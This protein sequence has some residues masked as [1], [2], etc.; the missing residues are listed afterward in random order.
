MEN[1]GTGVN[2]I[3]S[4]FRLLF[5]WRQLFCWKLRPARPNASSPLYSRKHKTFQGRCK[6]N[7]SLWKWL[8]CCF[9]LAPGSFS[10]LEQ[11]G[12]EGHRIFRL[13]PCRLGSCEEL[14]GFCEPFEHRCP[15]LRLFKLEFHQRLMSLGQLPLQSLLQRHSL[16]QEE[17]QLQP[18]AF[19]GTSYWLGI[20]GCFPADCSTSSR[21]PCAT[22]VSV[23]LEEEQ[24]RLHDGCQSWRRRSPTRRGRRVRPTKQLRWLGVLGTSYKILRLPLHRNCGWREQATGR[25]DQILLRALLWGRGGWLSPHHFLHRQYV[26]G[27]VLPRACIFD[28]ATVASAGRSDLPLPPQLFNRV[29][30]TASLAV[31]SASGGVPSPFGGPFSP[32]FLLPLCTKSSPL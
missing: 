10:S 29:F 32:L 30:A 6:W 14:S 27:L 24:L 11:L 5:D 25:G 18:L 17:H 16:L 23:E 2:L 13:A 4:Q 3:F 9:S 7:N 31:S 19:L 1:L 28:G 21:N 26:H 20:E 15:R 12:Q 8:W 22:A